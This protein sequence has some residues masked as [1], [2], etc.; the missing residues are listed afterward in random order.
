MMHE[1]ILMNGYGT[2]VWTAFTFTLAGFAILYA[3]T[4]LQLVKEQKRFVSKFKNL[5][6]VKSQSAKKQ[7]TNREILIYSSEFKI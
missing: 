2:Y 7:N 6:L 5:N 1:I 4:K 3:I